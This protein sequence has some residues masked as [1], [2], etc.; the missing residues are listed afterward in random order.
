MCLLGLY[1]HI[2]V[3]QICLKFLSQRSY[4]NAAQSW[5]VLCSMLP[6]QK[7]G[8]QK[9]K[10][11]DYF[12]SGAFWPLQTALPLAQTSWA[13]S[14][15]A[16]SLVLVLHLADSSSS[17]GSSERGVPEARELPAKLPRAAPAPGVFTLWVQNK[18]MCH[19]EQIL[20]TLITDV[21]WA[22]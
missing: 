21:R 20:V 14:G 4:C 6:A 3:Y 7:A 8:G 17:L 9:S 2:K 19:F 12:G 16:L 13:T 10:A 5:P 1:V 15:K 11:V 22:T 18:Y